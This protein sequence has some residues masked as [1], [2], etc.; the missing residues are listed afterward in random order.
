MKKLFIFSIATF[1]LSSCASVTTGTNQSISI[2]TEPDKAATCELNNDKGTWYI[3]S[4]PGSVIVHRAYSD[5]NI[6]CRKGEKTGNT[7]VKSTTKGMAFG[8]ILVGGIIGTGVDMSTGAAYDYPTA[9]SV[10][11]K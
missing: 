8:N 10:L 5:L 11:L 1:C 2:N 3:P 7:I 4:T 6:V 9:I